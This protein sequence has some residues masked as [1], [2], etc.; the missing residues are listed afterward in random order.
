MLL[1]LQAYILT[2]V[3]ILGNCATFH[4]WINVL[5]YLNIK[6]FQEISPSLP[7]AVNNTICT[8]DFQMYVD[9][10]NE[11]Y[12]AMQSEYLILIFVILPFQQV[13]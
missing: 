6:H 13:L 9:Q 2:F 7:E 12:W 5:P 1:I 8:K 3:T 4:Q 11:S 10:I